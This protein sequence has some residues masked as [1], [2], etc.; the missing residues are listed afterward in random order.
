MGWG[1]Q[2]ELADPSGHINNTSTAMELE[3]TMV[4]IACGAQME[5]G[6]C[7]IEM[8]AGMS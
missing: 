7:R 6:P 8:I 1:S 5:T 2:M 4:A 3:M